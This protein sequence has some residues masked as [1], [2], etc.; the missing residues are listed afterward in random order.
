MA[1]LKEADPLTFF[2]TWKSLSI[3]RLEK[4]QKLLTTVKIFKATSVIIDAF[5]SK[6]CGRFRFIWRFSNLHKWLVNL[7]R[8]LF[9]FFWTW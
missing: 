6:Y 4:W 8:S 7:V 9:L 1:F 3:D 2:K 5:L